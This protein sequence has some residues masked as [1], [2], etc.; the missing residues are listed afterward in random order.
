MLVKVRVLSSSRRQFDF[1]N[2][3]ER[4]RREEAH[5]P[6]HTRPP[7]PQRE[8]ARP[9]RSLKPASSAPGR[10]PRNT[11]AKE[12]SQRWAPPGRL[13]DHIRFQAR[14]GHRGVIIPVAKGLY[15]VADVKDATLEQFGADFGGLTTAIVS[16]AEKALSNDPQPNAQRNPAT[17]ELMDRVTREATHQVLEKVLPTDEDENDFEGFGCDDDAACQVCHEL[18]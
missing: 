13:G 4:L 12:V 17:R 8:G 2:W 3:R 16:T 7:S 15:L 10:Q 1:G 14:E 11:R 18:D 9:G 5:A 6:R